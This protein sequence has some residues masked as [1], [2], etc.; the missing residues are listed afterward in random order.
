MR[1]MSGEGVP[2]KRIRVERWFD[3]R[4]VGQA[5]S[6]SVPAQGD[7]VAAFHRAHDQRHGYHDESRPVEVV[8]VRCRFIGLTHKPELPRIARA[9]PGE[10]QRPV[11]SVRCGFAGGYRPAALYRREDLRAGHQ[12]RGPA[13]V[14]EYS[15][16]T[17]V[18]PDWTLRVDAFGNLF[19]TKGNVRG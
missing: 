7:F 19:L 11:E 5:Y 14:T 8:N 13:V 12:L 2:T 1:A 9:K 17:V 18:P 15:A 4:Y 16:T 3:V 6:L 10:A